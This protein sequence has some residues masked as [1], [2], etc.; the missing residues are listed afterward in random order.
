MRRPMRTAALA[1]AVLVFFSGAATAE[2]VHEFPE[3]E[4]TFDGMFGTF[5]PAQLRR[6]FTVY[7]DVCSSCHALRLVAYRSLA[8]IGFGEEEIKQIAAQ[9]EVPGE[10]D[11]TGEPTMRP[12]TPADRFVPPF[13]NEQAARAANNGALPPDLSL[14]AKSREGGPDYVHALLV[15]Y[16]DEPPQGVN[17]AEGMYYNE[18]FPNNQ[19]AMP[20]P[21]SEGLVQYAD[22]TEATVEQMS[23]DVSAFLTWAAE[24]HL[25]TRKRIGV[26]VVLFL[27]VLT[28][29]LYAVKK[30]VWADVH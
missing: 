17:L 4:W 9:R 26:K 27:I 29:L 8:D 19:I 10:P 25:A 13:P 30:K 1:A 21:L 20:P 7:Q 11:D 15:G 6:G 2:E 12:A 3:Q 28:G 14:M 23:S 24:P 5:N 22:G 18:Y 16:R